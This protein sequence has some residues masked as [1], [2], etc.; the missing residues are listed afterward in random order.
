MKKQ[1]SV[2]HVHAHA[3]R[4]RLGS[5]FWL[6]ERRKM[7]TIAAEHLDTYMRSVRRQ[8]S[9]EHDAAGEQFYTAVCKVL[10][11]NPS[12]SP[13]ALVLDRAHMQ[14]LCDAE[15]ERY[16]FE[17]SVKVQKCTERFRQEK[18]LENDAKML[19]KQ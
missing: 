18:E 12:S 11:E 9:P 2:F 10:C 17:T 7:E 3:A 14:T 5:G 4:L 13:L 15:R 16:V 6:Q 1:A 19:V 8:L